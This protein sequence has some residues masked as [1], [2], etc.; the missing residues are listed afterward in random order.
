V[1]L[2][3]EGKRQLVKLRK[4]VKGIEEAALAPLDPR[5]RDLLHKAVLTLAMHNDPRLQRA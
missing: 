2:T 1:S 5:S 3:S 4:V